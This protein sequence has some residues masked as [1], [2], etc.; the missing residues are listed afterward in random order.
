MFVNKIKIVTVMLLMALIGSG[1]LMKGVAMQAGQ[2]PIIPPATPPASDTKPP[3]KESGKKETER[4][5]EEC[6]FAIKHDFGKVPNWEEVKH[7]ICLVNRSDVPLRII[8]LR[9]P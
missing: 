9:F 4:P 2:G 6:P 8:S 1:V 5:V 7:T 3:E